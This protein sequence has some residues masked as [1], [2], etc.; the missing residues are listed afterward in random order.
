MMKAKHQAIIVEFTNDMDPE[1]M[2]E[3][4]NKV[5]SELFEK[6]HYCSISNTIN[7]S[8][9]P[10]LDKITKNIKMWDKWNSISDSNKEE[11]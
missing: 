6:Y 7:A 11:K 3:A 8:K 2:E 10:E 1:I 4:I 9:I 5:Q